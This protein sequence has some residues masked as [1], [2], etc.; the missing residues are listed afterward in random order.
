MSYE[1]IRLDK[2]NLKRVESLWKKLNELHL[3]E[4]P[5]FKEHYESFSFSE[6]SKKLLSVPDDDLLIEIIRNDQKVCG[7]CISS[8]INKTGEIES[9]FILEEDRGNGL[10]EILVER[11]ITWL[12]SRKCKKI[13]VS[14]SYGHES[15]FGFYKKFGLFPRLTYLQMKDL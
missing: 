10:G 12:K 8:I 7:Y 14:V 2:K 9:L 4:S 1:I 3:Q 11:S 15:V 13:Q 6:R 5:Y